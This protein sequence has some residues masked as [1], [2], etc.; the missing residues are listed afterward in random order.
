MLVACAF[1][2]AGRL[3]DI[4]DRRLIM[5]CALCVFA[6]ASYQ[7]TGLSLD[8]PLSWMMWIA[9]LRF[10]AGSF[11]FTSATAAALSQL[12]PEQVRMGS[13]LLNL[14]QNGIG[15]TIGLAVGTT[16]LQRRMT[17]H[18]S[19]LDQ[20]QLVSG[21]S[22]NEILTPVRELVQQAGSLGPLGEAQVRAL[23]HRHLSQQATVAA[24]QDCYMLVM[25]LCLASMSMLLLLRKPN[26]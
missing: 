8:R 2:I 25:L 23:V 13:G 9:A 1:P 12:P 5:F 18:S 14:M 4:F 3:A 6:L 7:F 20:Q 15:A 11:L 17:F 10:V 19:L 16:V 24:Y 22:W 21:L 26:E